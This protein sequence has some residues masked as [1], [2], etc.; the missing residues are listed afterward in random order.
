V[1]RRDLLRRAGAATMLAA[2]GRSAP[3]FAA[4][5][6][7]VVERLPDGA[8]LVTLPEAEADGVVWDVFFRVG[9]ADE[10]PYHGIRSLLSRCWIGEAKSRS[11][12]LLAGDLLRAGAAAGTACGPDWVEVWSAS[13]PD[14]YDVEKAA[15]TLFTNVIAA[16]TFGR[17]AVETARTE[18]LRALTLRRDDLL[19]D[20]L[21]R[22]Q[23]RAFGSSP[24]GGTPLGTE[25]T[26]SA[27]P[28]EQVER[29]YH[30][31]FRPERAVIVAAGR[32]TPEKA[33]SRTLASLGAAGW[34]AAGPP[35]PPERPAAL[36]EALPAGLRDLKVPRRAPASCVATAYLA[37]GTNGGAQGRTD[38]AAL[39]VLDAVLRGGKAGRLFALRDR[40]E[41]GASALGYEIRTVL[42]P[43]RAQN[44][45]SAY[46]VG[47][48]S[49]TEVR[50]RLLD[51][52]RAAAS[53]DRA[54]SEGEI[55]RAKTYLKARHRE[56]RERLKE[57]AFGVGWAE[58]MGLGA[59]FDSDY[60]LR[61]EGVTTEQVSRAAREILGGVPAV[62]YSMPG[63]AGE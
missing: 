33:R 46:V 24:Y 36:A 61:M 2:A 6:A 54:M 8:T 34:D 32:I 55:G 18:Q 16:A 41:G 15:Q 43:G 31:W 42:L 11:A 59:A 21:D 56:Q 4:A 29:F 49:P 60:D 63:E 62:V 53:G 5:A 50:D 23:V 37:P 51:T 26:V 17:E 48:Q 57:R 9:L 12:P 52:L 27:I 20:V 7:P 58:V 22:A 47:D 28:W 39:L 38:Y 30:R 25:E 13:G 14:P 19:F 45:W 10:G 40:P 44:L 1:T 35:A 3:A